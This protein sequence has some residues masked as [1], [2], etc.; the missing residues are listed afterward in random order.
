MR[1]SNNIVEGI[2]ILYDRK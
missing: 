2:L 1:I